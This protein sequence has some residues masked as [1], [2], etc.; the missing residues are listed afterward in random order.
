MLQGIHRLVIDEA[1]QS[2]DF[3]DIAAR[4]HDH[5]VA[6][7][8]GA[9]YSQLLRKE[10]EETPLAVARRNGTADSKCR[11]CEEEISPTRLKA[12]PGAVRCIDC[13]TRREEAAR[14]HHR[15]F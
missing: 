10:G 8:V 11:E 14:R 5:H 4:S 13:E 9:I 6:A 1:A 3:G 7:R 12:L 2:G 15:R